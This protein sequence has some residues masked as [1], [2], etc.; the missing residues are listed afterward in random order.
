M[1]R[2]AAALTISVASA[3]VSPAAAFSSSCQGAGC[4]GAADHGR[5]AA[6]SAPASGRKGGA[7]AA[8][9]RGLS[10]PVVFRAIGQPL[11]EALAALGAA[12]GVRIVVVGQLDAS[13]DDWSIRAPLKTALQ[14][15]ADRHGLC[16]HYDGTKVIVSGPGT[17][18]IQVIDGADRFADARRH[19]RF[20]LPWSSH[21]ALTHDAALR[22]FKVCGPAS[23][24][25]MAQSAV[26]SA[27]PS[28]V[29]IIRAGQIGD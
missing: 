27:K 19:L 29:R 10:T 17:S 3:P 14:E 21:N 11:P 4:K 26:D 18:T 1:P 7:S 15:L 23:V 9:S 25:A 8:Q 24:V 12:A 13:V 5:S 16:V 22:A 20:A 2:L 28:A 6:A